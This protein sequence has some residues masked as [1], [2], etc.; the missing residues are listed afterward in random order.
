MYCF[1]VLWSDF[2]S[3][4]YEKYRALKKKD[5]KILYL[6]RSG[7]FY[8]FLGED[9]DKI[10]EYVVLKKT[11]FCKEAMKCGFPVTSLEAYLRVFHNHGLKVEVIEK[12]ESSYEEILSILKNLDLDHTTPIRALNILKKLKESLK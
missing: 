11:K 8:I 4:I 12:D 1:F 5:K 10:N 6:F 9:A 3:Q 2:M 7:N